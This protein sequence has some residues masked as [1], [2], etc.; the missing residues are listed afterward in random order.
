MFFYLR[1]FIFAGFG[2]GS[3]YLFHHALLVL[4]GRADYVKYD[5]FLQDFLGKSLWGIANI[6]DKTHAKTKK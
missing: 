1:M 6:S 2:V 4:I 3:F 5:Y